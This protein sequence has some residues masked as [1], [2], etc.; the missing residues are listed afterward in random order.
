MSSSVATGANKIVNPFIAG[1][2]ADADGTVG[3]LDQVNYA[4][5]GIHEIYDV[6]VPYA[7]AVKI[8]NAFTVT[9]V[10]GGGASADASVDI[11]AAKADEFAAGLLAAISGLAGNNGA[12]YSYLKAQSR[13]EMVSQLSSDTLADMLEASD[14]LTY[15]IVI[16]ASNGASNMYTAIAASGE[17]NKRKALFTQIPKTT[18]DLYLNETTSS[19]EFLPLKKGDIIAFVFD[20]T[21]GTYTSGSGAPTQGAEITTTPNDA[22][23]ASSSLAA[24][25]TYNVGSLILTAPTS[26]RVAVNVKLGADGDAFTVVDGALTA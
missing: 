17:A 23:T 18:A 11:K 10:N 15:D 13:A 1:L 5:T 12:M 2:Y 7:D 25:N 3:V 22:S 24:P 16:D 14:L 20:A 26:R 19:L 8:L 9:D 4:I 6:T 21:I